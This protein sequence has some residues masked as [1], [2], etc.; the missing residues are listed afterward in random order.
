MAPN[1]PPNADNG[2]LAADHGWAVA[3]VRCRACG[4]WGDIED[5][6][7]VGRLQRGWRPR[8]FLCSRAQGGCGAALPHVEIILGWKARSD[9][10]RR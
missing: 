8:A 2:A 7:I 1:D 10:T 6:T 4:R 5:P 9:I 3:Y